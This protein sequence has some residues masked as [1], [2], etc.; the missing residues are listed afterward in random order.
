MVQVFLLS[1]L[2]YFKNLP[3]LSYNKSSFLLILFYSKK[4]ESIESYNASLSLNKYSSPNYLS[5][6]FF[7]LSLI[8]FSI[9]AIIPIYSYKNAESC[10]E[11][12]LSYVSLIKAINKFSIT[13]IRTIVLVKKNIQTMTPVSV[14]SSPRERS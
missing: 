4:F 3:I 10:L 14:Y 1:R 5:N 6:R 8:F 7:I 12:V 13:I 9:S 2:N 11:I